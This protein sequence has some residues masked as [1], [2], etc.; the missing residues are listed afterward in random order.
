MNLLLARHGESEWIVRGDEAGFNSPL[1]DR[2]RRQARLLGRW[3]AANQ[4][5]DAIYASPLIRAR[6]TAEIVAA[7][8]HLPVTLDHDLREFEVPYWED[9][10]D[11][12]PPY[13]NGS[14]AAPA[15]LAETYLPF[16]TRVQ[17]AAQRILE[18][19]AGGTV[20][21]VAHGGTVGTI[22]RCLLGVHNFGV[23]TDPTGLHRLR[24]NGGRWNIEFMNRLDHL[25]EGIE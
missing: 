20:L 16:K 2:G 13:F 25:R 14:A 18:A 24:W 1:T 8:L 21:I 12:A 17:R 7:E 23:Q 6:D 3:L 4:K 19:H 10:D 9:S 22:V 11:Y 5:I 15:Y